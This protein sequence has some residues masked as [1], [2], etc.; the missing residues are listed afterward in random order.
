MLCPFTPPPL[1]I[2][3][4]NLEVTVYHTRFANGKSRGCNIDSPRMDP[5]REKRFR[6]LCVWG[7]GRAPVYGDE[8]SEDRVSPWAEKTPRVRISPSSWIFTLYCACPFI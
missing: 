2:G 1:K 6:V 5:P 3:L 8:Q 7:E 4:G